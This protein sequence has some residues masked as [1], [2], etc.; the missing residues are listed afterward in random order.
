MKRICSQ[1]IQMCKQCGRSCNGG[2]VDSVS[3]KAPTWGQLANRINPNVE[4]KGRQGTLSSSTEDQNHRR[5]C[6]DYGSEEQD[7][8]E[9]MSKEITSKKGMS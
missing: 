8:V 3:L 5:R 6:A 2:W 4:I 7:T 9:A 1:N